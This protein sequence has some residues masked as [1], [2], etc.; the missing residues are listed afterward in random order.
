MGNCCRKSDQGAS[1]RCSLHSQLPE[2]DARPGEGAGLLVGWRFVLAA[3]AA[4]LLPVVLGAGAAVVAGFV[5]PARDGEAF[6]FLVAVL[7]FVV[8][9]VIAIGV[10]RH[11]RPQRIREPG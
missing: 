10:V 7:G 9:G 6:I 5:S 2:D 1:A 3:G 8:G 4:F 11:I